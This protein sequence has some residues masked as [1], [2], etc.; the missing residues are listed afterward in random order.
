MIACQLLA[1]RIMAPD[2][3]EQNNRS[4]MK[5]NIYNNA[6]YVTGYWSSTAGHVS[7]F[8]YGQYAELN[9]IQKTKFSFGT[10]CQSQKLLGQVQSLC[11]CPSATWGSF[12]HSCGSCSMHSAFL[13][14]HVHQYNSA[15][16]TLSAWSHLPSQALTIYSVFKF[17][18]R[19]K[20]VLG[21]YCGQAGAM[22]IPQHLWGLSDD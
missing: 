4:D 21:S 20:V 5:H 7:T 3:L 8:K 13:N 1:C 14:S 15:Q 22:T 9:F 19:T 2:I 10:M 17:L 11:P 18:L 12:M 16:N 6:I